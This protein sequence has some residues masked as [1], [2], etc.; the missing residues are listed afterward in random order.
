MD[1]GGGVAILSP[2]PDHPDVRISVYQRKSLKR[3]DIFTLCCVLVCCWGELGCWNVWLVM[4][5]SRPELYPCVYSRRHI[6]LRKLP[7]CEEQISNIAS[8]RE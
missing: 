6:S 7:E 2:R 4:C 5:V 1:K 3:V 8:L